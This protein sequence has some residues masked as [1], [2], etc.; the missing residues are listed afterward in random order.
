MRLYCVCDSCY[1][2]ASEPV[3]PHPVCMCT[4]HTHLHVRT[5]SVY[6]E[7]FLGGGAWVGVE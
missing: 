5:A 6:L 3:H 2:L 7:T 4:H 1:D